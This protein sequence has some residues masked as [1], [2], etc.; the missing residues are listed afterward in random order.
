[1]PLK[2]KRLLDVRICQLPGASPLGHPPGL[3]P[4]PTGDFKA[5][6]N[7][8]PST[9]HP[10]P[11][12]EIPGSATV[13]P[14][15]RV[16]AW[17]AHFRVLRDTSAICAFHQF[18]WRATSVA[19]CRCSPDRRCARFQVLNSSK[20]G[21]RA[22]VYAVMRCFTQSARGLRSSSRKVRKICVGYQWSMF[23]KI[24][25]LITFIDVFPLTI[26]RHMTHVS[27]LWH[28]RTTDKN[29]TARTIFDSYAID[30]W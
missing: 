27:R 12:S 19:V 22:Q 23:A 24:L 16:N 7:L 11:R 4:G 17:I 3:C 14:K 15:S 1:M 29:S 20:L 18:F 30:E 10:H 25:P 5:A 13:L 6:P 9:V 28:L 26:S 8:P 2:K 21:L